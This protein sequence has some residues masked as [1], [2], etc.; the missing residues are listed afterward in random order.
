VEEEEDDDEEGDGPDGEGGAGAVLPAVEGF[1][2]LG[3]KGNPD[4]RIPM[5]TNTARDNVAKIVRE[6]CGIF[7]NKPLQDW[8]AFHNTHADLMG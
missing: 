2:K 1:E 4:R 6:E 3:T 5:D 7:V 8:R